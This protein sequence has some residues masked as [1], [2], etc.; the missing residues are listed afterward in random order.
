MCSLIWQVELWSIKDFCQTVLEDA[1]ICDEYCYEWWS[2]PDQQTWLM[3]SAA[4]FCRYF[5]AAW[6][7]WEGTERHPS[8]LRNRVNP[9]A[10][11]QRRINPASM[12]FSGC[13]QCCAEGKSWRQ[14]QQCLSL[15]VGSLRLN[16]YWLSLSNC[17]K[18]G[19][20]D[21]WLFILWFFVKSW[22]KNKTTSF[23]LWARQLCV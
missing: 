9:K 8:P 3:G 11:N 10:E 5:C 2:S 14:Q 1:F 19:G 22:K 23:E 20:W 16:L 17:L 13:F 18:K 6:G 12:Y 15:A 7:L 21:D 4:P